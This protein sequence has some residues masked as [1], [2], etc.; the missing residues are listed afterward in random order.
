MT[1]LFH[2]LPSANERFK[3][4]GLSLNPPSPVLMKMNASCTENPV[5]MRHGSSSVVLKVIERS[6]FLPLTLTSKPVMS[7]EPRL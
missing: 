3:P 5:P 4:G 2:S 1:S 7:N 6:T